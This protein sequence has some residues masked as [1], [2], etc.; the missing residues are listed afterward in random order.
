[1]LTIIPSQ[2][3]QSNPT[4]IP[5]A[6]PTTSPSSTANVTS[7]SSPTQQPTLSPAPTNS[8]PPPDYTSTIIIFGVAAIAVVIGILVYFE[9]YYRE[10]PKIGT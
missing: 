2:S 4:I 6:T 9:K 1:M 7:T 10:M 8:Q 3:P 5:L